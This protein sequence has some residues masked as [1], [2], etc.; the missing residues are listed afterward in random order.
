MNPLTN[1]DGTTAFPALAVLLEEEEVMV[2]EDE[3]ELLLL[4]L[5][6][7]CTC[8]MCRST[9]QSAQNS[10]AV[11]VDVLFEVAVFGS[12]ASAD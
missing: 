5:Y 7:S 12:V 9:S 3:E 1:V 8:R 10:F 4:L 6:V 2:L 11:L